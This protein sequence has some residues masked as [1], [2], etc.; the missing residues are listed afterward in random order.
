VNDDI[1]DELVDAV[2]PA[3]D[4]A[5]TLERMYAWLRDAGRP[6]TGVRVETRSGALYSGVILV[7]QNVPLVMFALRTGERT[8]APSWWNHSG[9]T[10]ADDDVG[11]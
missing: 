7:H 9:D 4:T 10:F 5:S 6:P 1:A 11:F 3:P 8:S 2:Q